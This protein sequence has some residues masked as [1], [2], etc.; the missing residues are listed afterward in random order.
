MNVTGLAD[1][2]KD[3]LKHISKFSMGCDASALTIAVDGD[4]RDALK[5]NTA[6]HQQII[7]SKNNHSIQV[8]QTAKK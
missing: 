5:I 7:I 4:V 8:I 2:T 6:A 1:C 3:A